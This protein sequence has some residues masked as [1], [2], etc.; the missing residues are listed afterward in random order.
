MS[1]VPTDTFE[2]L[3]PTM[4]AELEQRWPNGERL[5]WAWRLARDVETCADLIAGHPVEESRLE[6]DALFEARR[7][8]LVQLRAPIELL[9]I[10]RA[11]A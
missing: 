7:R 4:R 5:V 10:D 8:R 9:N 3:T 11:A 2:A 6:P 1:I